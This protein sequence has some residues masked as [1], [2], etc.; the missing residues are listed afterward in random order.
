[1]KGGTDEG[2]LTKVEMR[3]SIRDGLHVSEG[4]WG[5]RQRDICSPGSRRGLSN[6]LM[7]GW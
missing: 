2:Q 5:G 3:C 6:R 1:M 7:V 4:L